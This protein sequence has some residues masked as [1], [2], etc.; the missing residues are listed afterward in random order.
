M[1]CKKF[2]EDQP[3]SWKAILSHYLKPVGG[4]LVLA[5]AFDIKKLPIKLPRFYEECLK[6][7]SEFSV[8]RESNVQIE[9]NDLGNIVIWNNKN[10]CVNGKSTFHFALFNEGIVTLDDLLTNRNDLIVKQ[11][12]NESVLTPLEIFYLMRI[13]D[14]L[15]VQW[16]ALLTRSRQKNAGKDF[17]LKDR[18]QLRLDDQDVLLCKAISKNI[19]MEIRSSFETT[20]TAQT[21]F[22]GQFSSVNFEWNEIYKLPF[23]VAMDTKTRE[24]QY[25]ILHRYLTTNAFLHKI[26]LKPSAV[27]TFCG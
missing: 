14:A 3:S 8:T 5:C 12:L 27:C 21:R 17:I 11:N 19:Y 4:K 10:I 18:V 15:P 13:I 25:K 20:P 7:F 2:A 24:F 22:E 16:R 6:I 1:C 9:N 26:G 23:K